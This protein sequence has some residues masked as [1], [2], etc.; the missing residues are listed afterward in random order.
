M[1]IKTKVRLVIIVPVLAVLA[2]GAWYW[3]S[4]RLVTPGGEPMDAPWRSDPLL[5]GKFHPE[6]RDDIQV[7]VH[8]GNPYLISK[9]AE[10]V[11]VRVTGRKGAAYVGVCLNQPHA[12]TSV[13]EGDRLLFTVSASGTHPFQIAESYIEDRKGWVISPCGKCGFTEMFQPPSERAEQLGK[14]SGVPAG[15][16]MIMLST[17]CPLCGGVQLLGKVGTEAEAKVRNHNR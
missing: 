9:A 3:A 13:G 17:F 2:L 6:C 7:L 1:K 8:D 15:T 16:Q 11:W 14:Q 10:S 4:S 5:A 12:V